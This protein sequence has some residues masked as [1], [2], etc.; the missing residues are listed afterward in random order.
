MTTADTI[1]QYFTTPMQQSGLLTKVK[2]AWHFV[3]SGINAQKMSAVGNYEFIPI[4]CVD[5]DFTDA[6]GFVAN[7]SSKFL[8]LNVSPV[9]LGLTIDN[10]QMVVYGNNLGGAATRVLIE[11]HNADI[12]N[13]LLRE[14]DGN[15]K[16]DFDNNAAS[17]A[18]VTTA[19]NAGMIVAQSPSPAMQRINLN[20]VN[21]AFD[22]GSAYRTGTLSTG[23]L[24]VGAY[25]DNGS[26][27]FP[28]NASF[29]FVAITER[30]TDAE[31]TLFYNI[32]EQTQV[33]LSRSA[34]GATASSLLVTAPSSF[35]VTQ[36]NLS[37]DLADIVVEGVYYG[38]STNI[39]ARLNTEPWQIIAT[40]TGGYWKGFLMGKPKGQY[41]LQVRASISP[42]TVVTKN[43]VGVG[44][45]LLVAGQSNAAGQFSSFQAYTGT[46]KASMFR[47]DGGGILEYADPSGAYIGGGS[48]WGKVASLMTAFTNAPVMIVNCG[49][50]STGLVNAPWNSVNGY[51]YDQA[52]YTFKQACQ[53]ALCVLYHQGETDAADGSA[54]NAF[55]DALIAVA[56]GFANGLNQPD[57]KMLVASLGQVGIA[58]TNNL[59]N[60]RAAISEAW[61]ND[62]IGYAPI[63]WNLD[64][65]DDLHLTTNAEAD[66]SAALWFRAIKDQILTPGSD[67]PPQFL[68]ATYSGDKI[69]VY[70]Q[71]NETA[72]TLGASPTLNW[73]VTDGVGSKTVSSVALAANN[74]IEL[75]CNAALA[76]SVTLSL[77]SGNGVGNTI[78]DSNS[79]A[80]SPIE[81][82]VGK[83]VFLQGSTV[84][85]FTLS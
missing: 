17:V 20:G 42:G 67:R 64:L 27:V 11:A 45:V 70:F 7:G 18:F 66:L 81:P 33:A 82:F 57:L 43:Y 38:A 75:T 1:A 5:G 71:G 23:K 41:T 55:R 8:N 4:G 85:L 16:V 30:M 10:I 13:I 58:T 49:F 21:V 69:R 32:V 74:S 68:S 35:Q 50:G 60:I 34:T 73:T 47:K 39:E 15:Y 83:E 44:D 48:V 78:K 19:V 79:I 22:I 9:E 61:K 76:G 54:K 31:L 65:A 59:N 84:N 12:R 63:Y 72:L 37:N 77:G 29:R 26:P 51:A 56:E 46:I 14:F 3:G 2:A 28:S 36:R 40:S 52:L 62:Q 6:T 53:K 25:N 80:P 24:A